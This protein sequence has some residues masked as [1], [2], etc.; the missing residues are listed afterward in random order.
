MII[1]IFVFGGYFIVD[2][3]FS[4]ILNKPIGLFP[5][6]NAQTMPEG[7]NE[8]FLGKSRVQVT[9]EGAEYVFELSNQ[10]TCTS[11]KDDLFRTFF[12]NDLN[13]LKRCIKASTEESLLF[14]FLTTKKIKQEFIQSLKNVSFISDTRKSEIINIM[15]G[16][17]DREDEI[18][19]IDIIRS[20]EGFNKYYSISFYEKDLIKSLVIRTIILISKNNFVGASR[21][22]EKIF[23]SPEERI[24][25]F[26]NHFFYLAPEKE[27]L[28]DFLVSVR[29]KVREADLQ[30]SEEKANIAKFLDLF[31]D[32]NESLKLA[33]NISRENL[34]DFI[35][36]GFNCEEDNRNLTVLRQCLLE[37][38]KMGKNLNL[39]LFKLRQLGDDSLD[40]LWLAATSKK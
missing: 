14:E 23:S 15:S 4:K 17:E 37:R 22:I 33:R 2:F 36:T 7:I 28:F 34:G 6:A 27:L 38:L 11:S 19:F 25:L 26:L 18:R 9:W 20:E 12:M 30:E 3:Y 5:Q 39:L 16:V 13:K 31:L 32:S 40:T 8:V 1:F 24:I 10:E 21:L 35:F 29:K